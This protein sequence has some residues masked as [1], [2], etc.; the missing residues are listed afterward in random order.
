[1]EELIVSLL[2]ENGRVII[3]DFGALIVKTQSPFTVIF[4]EFLQYNDGALISATAKKENIEREDA[5][6]KVKDFSAKIIAD[7]DSNKPVNLL[8][9]GILSKSATGK[10]SLGEP[11]SQPEEPKQ[12]I[13]EKPSSVEFDI[14]EN[15]ITK[16]PAKKE[17]TVK[18]EKPKTPIIKEPKEKLPEPKVKT[19][20]N[21]PV[22]KKVVSKEV[23]SK[24][25]TPIAEYYEED[26]SKSRINYILWGIL[27]VLVNGAIIGYF[28]FDDEIKALFGKDKPNQIE[29][30]IETPSITDELPIISTEP[31]QE[32]ELLIESAPEETVEVTSPSEKLT[33]KKYFIVAGVFKEEANADNLVITLRNKGYNAEKFGKIGA[34]H[35]VSYDVFPTKKEADQ[36]MLKIKNDVDSEAWIRVM[37]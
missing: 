34:L 20:V 26:S 17:K 4:N 37:N 3:P 5:A 33:G 7:L 1:M 25:P 14:T 32:E 2:K 27:I 16:E 28:L 10:I 29:Q 24:E 11:N 22:E 18:E 9:I 12:K 13:E 8:E 15:K 19:P 31:A 30:T 23:V 35:A 6:K 21:K 36:F